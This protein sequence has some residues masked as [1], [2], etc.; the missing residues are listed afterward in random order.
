LIAESRGPLLSAEK[1]DPTE[2]PDR[3]SERTA[4]IARFPLELLLI[5]AVYAFAYGRDLVGCSSTSTAPQGT[6]T[7]QTSTTA[8]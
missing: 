7:V 6:A 3:T 2:K 5:A 4:K 8:R 1:Q